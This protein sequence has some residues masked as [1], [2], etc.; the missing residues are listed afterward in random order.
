MQCTIGQ[1]PDSAIII[2]SEHQCIFHQRVVYVQTESTQRAYKMNIISAPV[3]RAVTK[4]RIYETLH[5]D[6]YLHRT[7]SNTQTRYSHTALK[8]KN[9]RSYGGV[10]IIQCTSQTAE[11]CTDTIQRVL[12]VAGLQAL[13]FARPASMAPC[14]AMLLAATH[15]QQT[16][17]CQDT[18]LILKLVN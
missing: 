16:N 4:R 2:K 1:V 15:Q 18:H 13:P 12:V 6:K 9:T 10:E 8:Y 7:S 5:I 11:F 3:Q 14:H 17:V